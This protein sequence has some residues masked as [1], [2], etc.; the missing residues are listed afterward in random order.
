MSDKHTINV[1]VQGGRVINVMDL[2]AD[3]E[4]TVY[5][6]DANDIN[7]ASEQAI[8]MTSLSSLFEYFGMRAWTYTWTH[9]DEFA[10]SLLPGA[11][12]VDQVL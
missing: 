4:V 9:E 7:P 11:E 8:T 5:D 12:V 10:V 1:I 3:M 2:P 6:L